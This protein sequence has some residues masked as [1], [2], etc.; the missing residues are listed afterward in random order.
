MVSSATTP[1]ISSWLDDH[2]VNIASGDLRLMANADQSIPNLSSIMF[3][4]EA[5]GKTVLF[6]GDGRSD[7]LLGGL[8]DAGLLDGEGKFHVDVFKVSH[9]GSDRNATK[10]FFRKVTADTYVISANGHPDNPDLST[11]IWIVE[12][13]KLQGRQIHIIAT[14][15]TPSL[16]KLL[17]EYPKNEFNYDLEIMPKNHSFKRVVMA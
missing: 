6:T 13:A 3:L 11:L 17:E 2:E 5:E 14:N 9:H 7:H 1:P 15:E 8:G 10:T 12:A 4:A 16:E